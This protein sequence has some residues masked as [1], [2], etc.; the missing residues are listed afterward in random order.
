MSKITTTPCLYTFPVARSRTR[1]IVILRLRV[2]VGVPFRAC[3]IPT[4][5]ARRRWLMREKSTDSPP[6]SSHTWPLTSAVISGVELQRDARLLREPP[7]VLP[8]LFFEQAIESNFWSV[9][10]WGVKATEVTRSRLFLGWSMGESNS[11]FESVAFLPRAVTR[12]EERG[13]SRETFNAKF[14]VLEVL[15]CQVGQ[16]EIPKM[17]FIASMRAVERIDNK[18]GKKV[19]A[20]LI[21]RAVACFFSIFRI[22]NPFARKLLN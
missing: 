7:C 8:F 10:R 1:A 20:D 3:I 2:H 18:I 17:W 13:S 14:E 21:G 6:T 4:V 9:K 15:P 11:C 19:N 16:W 5:V 22:L 12:I